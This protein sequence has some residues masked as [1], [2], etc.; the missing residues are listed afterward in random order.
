MDEEGLFILFA[1]RWAKRINSK[2]C[3]FETDC[4]EAFSLIQCFGGSV[5]YTGRSWIVECSNLLFDKCKWFLSLIRRESNI[6]A[7]SLAKKTD[8]ERWSWLSLDAVC[9]GPF[10]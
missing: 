4:V 5:H 6:V 2:D 10:S 7:D 3:I 8:V 1:M 9:H